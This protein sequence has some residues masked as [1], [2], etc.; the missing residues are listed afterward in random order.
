VP[1]NERAMFGNAIFTI[2]ASTKATT[3]PSDAI[4]STL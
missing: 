3:A 1:G 2:V 4:A